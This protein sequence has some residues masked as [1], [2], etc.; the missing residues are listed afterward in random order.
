MYRIYTDGACAS[1]G[2]PNAKASYSYVFPDHLQESY[3]EPLAEDDSQTNQTAELLAIYHGAAK[4]K[5]RGAT[6]LT[7]HTDS[8]YSKNCICT[9]YAGWVRKGWKTS[10]GKLVVHRVVIEKIVE[11][12]K[13]FDSYT[14]V[15]VP[16]H[17]GGDDEKSKWNDVADRMAV[18]ALDTNGPVHYADLFDGPPAPVLASE[19]ETPPLPDCPL[20]LMGP[21]VPE[22]ELIKYMRDHIEELYAQ[23]TDTVSSVLVTMLKKLLTKKGF[24]IEKQTIHKRTVYRLTQKS[25][26]K[27]QE[28]V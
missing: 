22:G 2:R 21:P 7:I 1:N 28:D 17:T 20:K 26:F 3:A 24:E 19:T 5:G 11:V 15:H 12:L 9:W 18:K 8:M 23:E 14:I 10:D 25:P 6:N 27:V 4:A 13:T 16:A